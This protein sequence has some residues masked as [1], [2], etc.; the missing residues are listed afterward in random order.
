MKRV[1]FFALTVPLALPLL[2]AATPPPGGE[3]IVTIA[4]L[5]SKNG[6][7]IACLTAKPQGFP[8]C[9]KDP[10]ARI[11][12]VPAAASA[13]LRFAAVPPGTYAIS[14]LH[15][16]DSNGRPAMAL[17]LPKEGFGV[18]R[19]AKLRFGPPKFAAAAFTVADQT[20]TM[21]IQMRYLF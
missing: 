19:N 21:P 1:A 17:F 12:S 13:S 20:V 4:G 6:Q 5:R 10:A 15:D 7:V 2:A 14:L 3:V 18:S 8:N 9:S 11:V 16:E